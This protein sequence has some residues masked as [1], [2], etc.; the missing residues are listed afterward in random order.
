M[1]KINITSLVLLVYLIV[2]AVIGRPGGS[3]SHVT[4]TEYICLIGASL[5][6]ILLLRVVQIKRLKSREKWR[7]ENKK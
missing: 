1:K 4:T 7:E 5:A 2:M 3:K 6:I